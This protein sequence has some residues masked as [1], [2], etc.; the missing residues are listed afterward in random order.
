MAPDEQERVA[1]GCT[2]LPELLSRGEGRGQ[3][4]GVTNGSFVLI[5]KKLPNLPTWEERKAGGKEEASSS[6]APSLRQKGRKESLW[7]ATERDGGG[8]RKLGGR[9][10]RGRKYL[11]LARGRQTA[12]FFLPGYIHI[13]AFLSRKDEEQTL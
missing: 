3:K 11:C 8:K 13:K 5:R 7:G 6:F 10:R 4:G 9:R 12:D 2:C 1:G